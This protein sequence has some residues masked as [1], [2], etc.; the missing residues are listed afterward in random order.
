MK[1]KPRKNTEKLYQNLLQRKTLEDLDD[2]S[3]IKHIGKL[4]DAS[5]DIE[6]IEGLELAERLCDEFSNRSLAEDITLILNLFR[7]NIWHARFCCKRNNS[8]NAWGWEQTELEKQIYHLRLAIRYTE[9]DSLDKVRRCQILTNAGNALNTLG[10]CVEAVEYWNRALAII[11]VFGMALGNLGYGLSYYARALYDP[12]HAGVML[13]FAY[14]NFQSATS[15]KTFFES[16]HYEKVKEAMSKE[17]ELIAAHIDLKKINA[18]LNLDNYSLGRSKN[19]KSYRLWCL[20][21]RLFLNPLNDLGPYTIAAQDILTLPDLVVAIGEPPTL[22]AFYNQLKQE[23]ISARYIYYEG[24]H[25]KGAHFADRDVLLYDTLDYPAYSLAVEKIK[26]A[27]R[28]SY[29][30]FDKLAFFIN[31][32]W[33]LDMHERSINFRSVWYSNKDKPDKNSLRDRFIDYENWPLRGLFWLSKDL[34]EEG[35]ELAD[36]VEPDAQAIKKVRNHLEHKYLKV[37][38]WPWMSADYPKH[39]FIRDSL[40][41]SLT[42]GDLEAKT[43]RLLKLARASLIY[44]ALAVHR[45]EKIR[46]EK[47]GDGFIAPMELMSWPDKWKR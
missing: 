14:D 44:L 11:P 1:E 38:D 18:S 25:S 29:S 28:I 31:A 10:R 39:D 21:H 2:E 27:F 46:G 5:V 17:A 45:E 22:I 33:K 13:K 6:H 12:G 3:A 42:R 9:F 40:A 43:L 34:L 37:H 36:T 15:P 4:I 16:P 41:Y 35:T 20:D 30:I 7:A 32:Y 47:R 19:E 23:Y 26:V 24:L 8:K